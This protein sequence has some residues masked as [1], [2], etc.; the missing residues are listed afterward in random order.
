[1][2]ETTPLF[3]IITVTYN[4]AETISVTLNSV[5][6]QSCNLYEYIIMDGAS[7]DATLDIVHSANIPNIKIYSGKDK[8]LY[9][10]MNKAMEVASGEYLIFLNAGDTFHSSDTLQKIADT[11][12]DNDF[13]GIVYGQTQL[14]NSS[15]Q[16]IGNRHLTA[17]V[18]LTLKSFATGMVVCHQAFI[19]LRRIAGS[20]DLQY[21]FSADYEW[22]IRCLQHSRHNVYIDDTLIDYLHE[23]L[24]TANRKSSLKERFN[25]MCHYYGTFSTIMRHISFIPRFIIQ[26]HKER[27]SLNK[28]NN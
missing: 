25:I 27:K 5:K 26:R 1:M 7:K 10:A 21:R 28:L 12:M 20:Y 23:G 16:Y 18:N 13:P 4:A 14:V 9:D 24:T 3:S 22:C 6:E 15:R 11:I 2:N 17:P 8:G 19:V